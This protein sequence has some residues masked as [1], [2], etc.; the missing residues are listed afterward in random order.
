MYFQHTLQHDLSRQINID[1]VFEDD[2][3]HRADLGERAHLDKAG[4]AGELEFKGKGDET[5]DL[6]RGESR[7]FGDDLNQ[8]RRD[9]GKGIDRDRLESIESAQGERDGD[10]DDQ[11]TLAESQLQQRRYHVVRSAIPITRI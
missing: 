8:N 1:G 3:D 7:R 2:V 5:F 11:D 4:G 9:V 6:F 10:D